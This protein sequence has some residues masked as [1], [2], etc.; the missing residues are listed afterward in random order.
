MGIYNL[1]DL[2]LILII[3]TPVNE[4]IGF[5]SYRSQ[6]RQEYKAWNA[7]FSLFAKEN[8]SL[9][10]ILPCGPPLRLDQIAF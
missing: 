10:L 6:Y 1:D 2:S 9:K 4:A 3:D 5:S 7:S 8:A